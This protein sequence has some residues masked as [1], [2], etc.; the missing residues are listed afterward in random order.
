MKNVTVIWHHSSKIETDLQSTLALVDVKVEFFGQTAHTSADPWNR[1][2]A[3]NPLELYTSGINY[4]KEYIK[5][6]LRIHYHI[7]DGGIR[8]LLKTRENPRGGSTDIGD[9]SW[10]VANINLGI[11]TTTIE[12]PW[13]SWA[14]ISYV[15]ISIGQKGMLYPTIAMS[16][17]MLDFF[18]NQ[19]CVEGIKLCMRGNSGIRKAQRRCSVQDYQYS[20]STANWTIITPRIQPFAVLI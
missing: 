1:L 13:H 10:N 17:T 16:M 6:K 20:W 11:T 19:K 7:Q 12:T 9:V 18:Q 4:Y 3:F 14:V 5:P 8:P 15:G 2:S